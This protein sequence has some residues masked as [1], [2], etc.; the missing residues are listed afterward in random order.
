MVI[1]QN[2]ED[3]IKKTFSKAIETHIAVALMKDYMS[4]L[5]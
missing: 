1:L 4:I 3:S 5:A 2:I